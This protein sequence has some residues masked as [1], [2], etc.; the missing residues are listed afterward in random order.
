MQGSELVRVRVVMLLPHYSLCFK[1]NDD[2]QEADC[3]RGERVK[4]PQ[5]KRWEDRHQKARQ[6]DRER[7]PGV[8]GGVPKRRVM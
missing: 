4:M 2:E 1:R 5:D 7:N 8:R 3:D 6:N